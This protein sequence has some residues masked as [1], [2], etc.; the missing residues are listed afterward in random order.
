MNVVIISDTHMP[1]KSSKMP[2]RL[3][4]ELKKADHIIHAGDWST[5]DVYD[6]LLTYAPITGV[7]GNIE[8]DC[9]NNK[10]PHKQVV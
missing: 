1:K 6:E 7:K 2:E 10:F 5:L 9:V 3:L 8:D 4:R